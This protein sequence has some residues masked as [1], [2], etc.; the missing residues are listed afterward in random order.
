MAKAHAAARIITEVA[1]PQL[2][3]VM[4]RRKKVARSLDTIAEDDRELQAFYGDDHH[5]SMHAGT[6]S[7][8]TFTAPVAFEPSG[9][10]RELSKCFS[11]NNAHG[12]DW[13][14]SSR[15]GPRPA[16]GESSMHSRCTR[17]AA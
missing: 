3:S 17:R 9:F 7:S 5:H 12:Q 4:R 6:S 11:N 10:I 15:K 13:P 2:V 16:T 14:E 8:S 1:P